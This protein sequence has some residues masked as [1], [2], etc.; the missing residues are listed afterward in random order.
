MAQSNEDPAGVSRGANSTSNA[1]HDNNGGT[2]SSGNG[3]AQDRAPGGEPFEP[4]AGKAGNESGGAQGASTSAPFE[5]STGKAGKAGKAGNGRGSA[6]AAK[7]VKRY[8]LIKVSDIAPRVIDW[9]WP[10]HLAR[11]E[12]AILTGSA[13]RRCIA[14]WWPR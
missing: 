7:P 12:L 2:H 4:S 5:P 3:G 14:S 8:E 6:Q 13:N 9:L 1:E 11:G 10:G